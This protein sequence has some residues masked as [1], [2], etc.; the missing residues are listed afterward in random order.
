M[1]RFTTFVLFWGMGFF[2]VPKANAIVFFSQ[3]ND[4][5]TTNPGSALPWD[6][7]VQ[8]RD[9][10]GLVGSGVYL[11]NRY[12]LT[13]AHLAPV[14]AV[15]V[16]ATDFSLDASTPIQIGSSDM[17]LYRLASDPGLGTVRLNSN[18]LYDNGS[19]ILVG[20]GLGRAT[21]SALSTSPV[22]WGDAS[23]A[24]KRWGS[25]TIDGAI[26]NAT[27]G[28]RTSNLLVTQFNTNSSSEEAAITLYD[29]GSAL[30][31]YLGSEW[32]LVGL[33]AYVQNSGYSVAST[34][35]DSTNSDDNYFIRISSYAQA[36]DIVGAVA[37]PEPSVRTLL[38]AG[39]LVLL[40]LRVYL[41]SLGR[42]SS[43]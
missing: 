24:V 5:N 28:G 1:K 18:S 38:L 2:L 14:S 32:Y 9:A 42:K 19:A 27:V 40:S 12:V 43:S 4:H 23:T 6:N 20:Y 41:A 21:N 22:T 26:Q 33:G 3:G 29:S 35:S 37:V 7:V 17:K 16:G 34:R 36:V 31:R 39:F 13:A 25:N 10:S 30:F 11:G 8:M 15:R